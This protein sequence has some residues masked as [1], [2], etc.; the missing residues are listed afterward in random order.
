[1]NLFV[2]LIPFLLMSA[3]FVQLGAIDAETPSR[4]TPS[5]VTEAADPK[6]ELRLIVQV[7]EKL[8]RVSAFSDAY[9]TRV[10]KHSQSI[11]IDDLSSLETAIEEITSDKVEI[12]TTLF[13]VE[14]N[15]PYSSAL[16]VL[17]SLRK[18]EGLGKVVLAT[19]VVRQ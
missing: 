18:S 19:E 8:I 17:G 7:D 12:L 5:E 15:T 13:R 3:A 1:M 11:A 6:P 2:C 4:G 9:K 10:E 14:G 16:A